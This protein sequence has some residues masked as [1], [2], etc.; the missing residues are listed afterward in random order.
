[1]DEKA[2]QWYEENPELME[3]DGATMEDF[4]IE[5]MRKLEV[6]ANE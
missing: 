1:M 2:K 4:E 3:A 5:R 6:G